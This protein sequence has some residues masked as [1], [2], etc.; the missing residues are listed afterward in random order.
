MGVYVT[1]VRVRVFC[2]TFAALFWK[3]MYFKEKR[4]KPKISSRLPAYIYTFNLYT[5]T[6]TYM[7][8]IS[9]FLGPSRCLVPTPGLTSSTTSSTVPHRVPHVQCVYVR[10]CTNIYW[11]LNH[12]YYEFI[13]IAMKRDSNLVKGVIFTNRS[14]VSHSLLSDTLFGTPTG[15]LCSICSLH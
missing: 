10:A 13:K 6:N 12:T 4:T 1:R 8:R 2:F 7:P 9:P 5:R 11:Y 15:S 14:C 3:K